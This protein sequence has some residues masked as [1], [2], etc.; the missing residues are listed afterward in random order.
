M[1]LSSLV[2]AIFIGIGVILGSGMIIE[3]LGSIYNKQETFNYT[4]FNLTSDLNSKI[5]SLKDK[6][7]SKAGF[8]PSAI[9]DILAF[10]IFDISSI[11]LSIPNILITMLNLAGKAL[12]SVGLPGWFSIMVTG[13]IIGYFVF[14][15][16]EVIF[17]REV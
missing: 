6:L 12:P 11:I 8:D 13:I 5:E 9:F 4:A 16:L 14:K 1:K 10:F 2:F 17:K 7:T 3:D 15:I